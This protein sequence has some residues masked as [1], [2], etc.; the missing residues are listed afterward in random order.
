MAFQFRA[1]GIGAKP[2]T[3]ND[4]SM[5][6]PADALVGELLVAE[7]GQNNTG[8][9]LTVPSGWTLFP[10]AGK[11]VSGS[12]SSTR[13]WL[14][15]KKCTL[16]DIG[17]TQT[18]HST[19]TSGMHGI[20]TSIYNDAG[21]TFP[22]APQDTNASSGA[23]SVSTLATGA[24]T[25]AQANELLVAIA[26][27]GLSGGNTFTPP[28]GFTEAGDTT[29]LAGA[30]TLAFMLQASAGAVGGQT[31]TASTTVNAFGTIIAAF[32]F[33]P[34]RTLPLSAA[35]S[36]S[37]NTRTLPLSAAL[38]EESSDTTVTYSIA[39]GADDA[40]ITSGPTFNAI[41][42]DLRGF[43]FS[44]NTFLRFTGIAVPQG[45]T[46]TA[47]SI[48]FKDTG[49]GLSGVCASFI[50]A[51]DVDDGVMPT[52]ATTAA[53]IAAAATTASVAWTLPARVTNATVTTPDFASVVQEITDRAGWASGNAIVIVFNPDDSKSVDFNMRRY[54]S[55]EHTTLDPALLSITYSTAVTLTRTVPLTAA[56]SKAGNTRAVPL[57]AALSRTG[58]TRTVPLSAALSSTLT[59]TVPLSAALSSTLTRT[60]PLSAALSSTLTRTVPL[61][62]ALYSTLTRS[63]PLTASLSRAG[64]TRI[65]PLTAALSRAS[66]TRTVPL[67]AALLKTL[68]RTVPLTASLATTRTRTVPTSAALSR[69]GNT[70]TVPLT[71]ALSG[72]AAHRL[73][74]AVPT[75]RNMTATPTIRDT[76]PNPT[77]RNT[78]VEWS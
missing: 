24:I 42:T 4:M 45:V 12:P 46:I 10:T 16:G 6:V 47:A 61:S 65:V 71:A 60:V 63:V 20:V 64:N 73:D 1:P 9:T 66:L 22:A 69:A 78:T 62:A 26:F 13:G 50:Q 5:T 11:F 40:D 70:R 3:G 21:G 15:W 56:L 35:L 28:S 29:N 52:D 75:V 34:S 53:S 8:G 39:A 41:R 55:F 32:K 30:G 48:D 72:A 14:A 59:R 49:S 23:N 33:T 37:S 31:F 57:S 76:T 7:V 18:W 68:T 77:I 58:N 25:T 67:S 51:S 36:S 17:A 54:A 44:E 74:A 19:S 38:E 43:G 2:A 27:T